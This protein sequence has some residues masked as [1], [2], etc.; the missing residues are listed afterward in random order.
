MK[1]KN[2]LNQMSKMGVTFY[3]VRD[4]WGNLVP[5]PK[6]EKG[7]KYKCATCPLPMHRQSNGDTIFAAKYPGTYH[8]NPVCRAMESGEKNRD[9]PKIVNKDKFIMKLIRESKQ[10]NGGPKIDPPIDTNMLIDPPVDPNPPIK[11]ELTI[12]SLK[13][14]K[15]SDICRRDPNE[16]NGEYR[17]IDIFLHYWWA[18]DFFEDRIRIDLGSRIV[19]CIFDFYN[20][21]SNEKKLIFR[22]FSYDRVEKK[23]VFQVKF[24]VNFLNEE[25]FRKQLKRVCNY[26]VNTATGK[27]ESH[28][29]L[30]LIAGIDWKLLS[31][32]KCLACCKKRNKDKCETCYGMFE[33]EFSSEK[34]IYVWENK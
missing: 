21:E 17:L 32:E 11:K 29:M 3:Y 24:C 27:M 20:N 31:R 23:T 4:E 34:Q 12:N 6:M 7:K 19:W 22:I 13:H 14:V 18:Q 16:M 25:A 15:E 26:R 1:K 2:M 30:A 10:K 9:F 5:A 33:T 8:L 28:P